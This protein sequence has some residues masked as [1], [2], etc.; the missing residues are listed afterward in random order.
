M[1]GWLASEYAVRIADEDLER[2][3][4]VGDAVDHIRRFKVAA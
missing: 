3:Q 2:F 1:G 4:T